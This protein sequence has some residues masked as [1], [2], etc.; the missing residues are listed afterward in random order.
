MP[1]FAD[2][3]RRQRSRVAERD[4]DRSWVAANG[5]LKGGQRAFRKILR[6]RGMK[7]PDHYRQSTRTAQEAQAERKFVE[8][9]LGR[10]GSCGRHRYPGTADKG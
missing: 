5:P 10:E 1:T 7:V 6:V 3:T 2:L 4:A 9:G 8:G